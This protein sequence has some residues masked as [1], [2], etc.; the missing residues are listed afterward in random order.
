VAVS[1]AV[2]VAT[3][4][5]AMNDWPTLTTNVSFHVNFL[6][7]STLT[8]SSGLLLGAAMAFLWRPWKVAG[9]AKGKATKVLD[10]VAVGAVALLVAAFFAGHWDADSTYL[11]MLPMVSIASAVLVA[12]VVHP[13]AA[14]ARA[15]L[16]W[17]PLVEIGKRSYGLYLWSWPIMRVCDAY[18]GSWPKFALAIA[19]TVPVNEAGYRWL[20]GPIRAGAISR[21]W[22]NRQRA[23]W[24]GVTAVLSVSALWLVGSMTYFFSSADAVFDAAV[25]TG[26]VLEFDADALASESTAPG[27]TTPASTP[28]STPDSTTPTE[29][30]TPTS[31]TQ[32]TLPRKLV[33]VGDSTA[34][35]EDQPARRLGDHLPRGRRGDLG[36]QCVHGWHRRV[37]H[38]VHAGVRQLWRLGAEVGGRGTGL[39][40]RG[41][42]RG[43]RRV[44]RVRREARR[45][46]AALRQRPG[47]SAFPRRPA[48][49]HRRHDRHRGE[50]RPAGSAVHAPAGRGGPGHPAPARAARRRASP[51][52]EELR[53]G[54]GNRP[55][56]PSWPARWST[57]PTSRSPPTWATGGMVCT[58]TSRAPS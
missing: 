8:R 29:S 1:L 11:W 23:S 31:T 15:V 26:A 44:G 40:R 56:P 20:E 25:D 45:Q 47:R 16:S 38:R 19:I 10:M 42:A 49:G 52:N 2:M 48:A 58:R 39:Q 41:R 12:V 6:Y 17:R 55:P 9:P 35:A 43:D 28:A 22:E 24:I 21:W 30:T 36:L 46:C 27:A 18:T 32:P 13:W 53:R 50:G 54:G 3:A 57:A 5:F 34:H 51:R 37:G 33:I 14:G 7:L 4:L